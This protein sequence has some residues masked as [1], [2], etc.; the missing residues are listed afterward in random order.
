MDFVGGEARRLDFTGDLGDC[1][2][3]S[4][5]KMTVRRRNED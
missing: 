1:G 3:E 2:C 5:E 4:Y